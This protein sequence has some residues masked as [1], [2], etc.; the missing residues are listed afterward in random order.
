MRSRLRSLSPGSSASSDHFQSNSKWRVGVDSFSWPAFLLLLIRL[1]RA[2]CLLVCCRIVS[3]CCWPLRRRDFIPPVLLFLH[4]SPL[5]LSLLV[6]YCWR[7]R[8]M[9]DSIKLAGRPPLWRSRCVSSS[10]Q[11][12]RNP[13]FHLRR[14]PNKLKR[15]AHTHETR[16]EQ[17]GSKSNGKKENETKKKKKSGRK[18]NKWW[19]VGWMPTQWVLSSSPLGFIRLRPSCLSTR[20]LA[21]SWPRLFFRPACPSVIFF[22]NDFEESTCLFLFRRG[23]L[24]ALPHQPTRWIAENRCQSMPLPPERSHLPNYSHLVPFRPPLWQSIHLSIYLFLCMTM[25]CFFWCFPIFPW[26]AARLQHRFLYPLSIRH[27]PSDFCV[28]YS[29]MQN[30]GPSTGP[31]RV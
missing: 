17:V 18:E 12:R 31:S 9:T 1:A 7:W 30:A 3:H 16:E 2:S 11:E 23:K 21:I 8:R 4:S 27:T 26:K 13:F 25:V 5:G 14:S 19:S 6:F 29:D 20:L 15:N 28:C 10:L 24:S 22:C